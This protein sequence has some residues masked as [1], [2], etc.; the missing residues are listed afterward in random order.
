MLDRLGSNTSAEDTFAALWNVESPPEA[1]LEIAEIEQINQNF[2]E[3]HLSPLAQK[4]LP[5]SA[6][7]SSDLLLISVGKALRIAETNLPA[8]YEFSPHKQ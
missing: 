8:A 1:D 6:L 2:P 7:F 4:S 3:R 5:P